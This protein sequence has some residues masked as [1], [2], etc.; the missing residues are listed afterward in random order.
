MLEHRDHRGQPIR[1]RAS[2]PIVGRVKRG[3][4]TRPKIYAV[5]AWR[6]DF[7]LIALGLSG[8][9]FV[10]AFWFVPRLGLGLAWRIPT[11]T[12][13]MLLLVFAGQALIA[14]MLVRLGRLGRFESIYITQRLE[15]GACGACGFGLREIPA[16]ED[17]CRMCPECGA[18]W[19]ISGSGHE[20]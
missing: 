16:G 17:G 6:M 14:N 3:L 18:A 1:L 4:T 8:V 13:G 20:G 9:F 15:N 10:F 5:P 7:G 2:G 11:Q 19:V 12:V